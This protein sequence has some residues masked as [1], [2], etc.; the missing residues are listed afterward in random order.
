MSYRELGRVER[1]HV[2][3]EQILNT[4]KERTSAHRLGRIEILEAFD[5]LQ[6]RPSS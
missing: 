5:L 3:T 4:T 6:L 1:T 2:G